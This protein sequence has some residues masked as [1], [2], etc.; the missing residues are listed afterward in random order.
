MPL[1]RPMPSATHVAFRDRAGGWWLMGSGWCVVD[2]GCV[3]VV[4]VMGMWWWV[5]GDG[6]GYVVVGGGWW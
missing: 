6:D 4:V 2:Y 1:D 5:V 3:V